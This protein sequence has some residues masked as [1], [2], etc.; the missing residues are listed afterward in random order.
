LR[1]E[2][3]GHWYSYI[4]SENLAILVVKGPALQPAAHRFIARR[5]LVENCDNGLFPLYRVSAHVERPSKTL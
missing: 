3:I 1:R 4:C 2:L 5:R